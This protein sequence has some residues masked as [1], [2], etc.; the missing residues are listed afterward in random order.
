MHKARCVGRVDAQNL[1]EF[2]RI[3]F[4]T[5]RGHHIAEGTPGCPVSRLAVWKE[6]VVQGC[7][8]R[9]QRIVN[10]SQQ[11]LGSDFPDESR[12]FF[13]EFV[14]ENV[15]RERQLRSG[16]G[17]KEIGLIYFQR[18]GSAPPAVCRNAPRLFFKN[19]ADIVHDRFEVPFFVSGETE[20]KRKN[21]EIV[22]PL[23]IGVFELCAVSVFCKLAVNG[24][25]QFGNRLLQNVISVCNDFLCELFFLRIVPDAFPCLAVGKLRIELAF[26][27]SLRDSK[28]KIL[29]QETFE[30]E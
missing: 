23:E 12:K 20:R 17:G 3:R 8:F 28:E 1:R 16:C 19:G 29:R 27:F 15:D 6:P 21:S 18:D 25:T 13:F 22:A 9:I 11:S 30:K 26:K 2:A 4:E 7:R 14:S 10:G 24:K 5:D